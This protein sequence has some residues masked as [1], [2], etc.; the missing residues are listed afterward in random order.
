MKT[1]SWKA[2]SVEDNLIRKPFSSFLVSLCFIMITI[3][4]SA[5]SKKN[6]GGGAPDGDYYF[7]A[8]IGGKAVNFHSVNFQGSGDD[9]RFEHIVIGGDE[10]SYSGSGLLPPSLDFEIWRLGGNIAA[11]T[12]ATPVEKGMIARYAIQKSDGTLVYNTSTSNDIFTVK[13]EAISKA[14]IRGAFSGTVRNSAGE[15]IDI[16]DG[17]FNLPYETSINP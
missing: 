15:A 16:T 1:L 17:T 10:T 14:G 6:D 12:Y 5:C 4:L 13:I 3:C 9:N 7:R 11:G 8:K 2:S